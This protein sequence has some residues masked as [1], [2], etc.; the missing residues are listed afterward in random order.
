[1]NQ[2]LYFIS[3]GDKHYSIQKKRIG[4]QAKKFKIF[5]NVILYSQNSLDNRFLNKFSNLFDDNIGG[6]YWVWKS[7]IV[8]KTF[9]L[10]KEGDI[11]LYVDSGS[12]LN[13]SGK[14]RL[15]DYIDKLNSS[16]KSILCFQ[17]NNLVEKEW[18][19]KQVFEALNVNN[20]P[21]I[22]NTPQIMGG[23]FLVKKSNESIKFFQNFQAHVHADNNL[24][25]NYYQ[26]VQDTKFKS[27]RHDQSLFSV[28]CKLTN[29]LILEDETYFLDNSHLQYDYPILTVRDGPYS[30]WQKIKFYVFYPYNIQKEIYF[31][32][33]KFYYKRKSKLQQKILYKLKNLRELIRKF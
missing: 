24:I 13:V 17:M 1:M 30:L 26:D 7:Y 6:G 21:H 10:M 25:T 11:L 31:G 19:T 2:K 32:N 3:Y 20:K 8:L 33:K 28:M 16:G 5:N 14:K 12:T 23:V 18:T 9:N 15:I 29:Q 22:T 27:C 4:Y